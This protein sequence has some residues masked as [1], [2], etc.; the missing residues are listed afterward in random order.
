MEKLCI[1]LGSK[2][3]KIIDQ[4]QGLNYGTCILG[5]KIKLFKECVTYY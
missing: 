5:N 2:N 1:C 4:N 3:N